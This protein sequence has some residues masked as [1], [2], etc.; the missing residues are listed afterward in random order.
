MPARSLHDNDLLIFPEDLAGFSAQ[1]DSLAQEFLS[2]KP[3]HLKPKHP[4]VEFRHFLSDSVLSPPSPPFSPAPSMDSENESEKWAA[5][6]DQ[7]WEVESPPSWYD[8]RGVLDFEDEIFS[9]AEWFSHILP[10]PPSRPTKDI[11]SIEEFDAQTVDGGPILLDV[12]EL[13]HTLVADRAYKKGELVVEFGTTMA[14]KQTNYSFPLRDPEHGCDHN[15]W[16]YQG[17]TVP[18]GL[19]PRKRGAFVNSIHCSNHSES[20]FVNLAFSNDIRRLKSVRGTERHWL[21]EKKPGLAPRAFFI[22]KRDIARGDHLLQCYSDGKWDKLTK[23]KQKKTPGWTPSVI[24]DWT[25]KYEQ[26]LT[27]CG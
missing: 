5:I 2:V 23:L 16:Q 7:A 9:T 1:E 10:M 11:F 3:I 6:L 26:F 13:G 27:L 14:I 8:D 20:F 18:E 25:A 17:Y 24:S 19:S 4:I 15:G 12:P 22:A 21:Q